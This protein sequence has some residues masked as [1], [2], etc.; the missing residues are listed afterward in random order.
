MA[1]LKREDRERLI[2]EGAI[3]FF[4]ERGFS[5]QTRELARGLGITQPLLYRYFSSKQALVDRVHEE[6]FLRRWNPAWEALAADRRLD[7]GER[8][9]LF[10]LEF[11]GSIFSREWVRM[12]VYSGLNQIGY[13]RQ[14]LHDIQERIL[15]RLCVELRIHCGYDAIEPSSVTV[16]E[17][18]YVW[19][20]HG[21]AFYFHVRK[22]VYELPLDRS[23]DELVANMA[24]SFLGGGP[25]VLERLLGPPRPALDK[26]RR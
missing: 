26:G 1:R 3:K 11:C 7:L 25:R 18:E 23:V 9:R 12:F 4:A 21:A 13:N 19:E 14:V 2:I 20:L 22:Y 10:Y 6:L 8:I 24:D 17:L 15:R 16:A 5:G